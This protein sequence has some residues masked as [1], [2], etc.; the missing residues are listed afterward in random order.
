MGRYA[1]RR[2][3]QLIP[4]FL[5]STLLL[6]AMV[7]MIPGDPIRALF[8]ERQVAEATVEQLRDRYNLND[9]F[10]V[11]YG[12]YMGFL[13]DGEDGFSGLLQGD[14]GEDF[15]IALTER[16][17]VQYLYARTLIGRDFARPA[18]RPRY[19]Q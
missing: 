13:P 16:E 14:L 11:Q 18:V 1:A 6:Y 2:L 10:F 5:G 19:I 3:L 12:K 15:G 4:V 17:I 9:P 8:G 7:F